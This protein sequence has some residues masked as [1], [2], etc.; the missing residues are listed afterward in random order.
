MKLALGTAQF[1]L[2][3]GIANQGGR[4]SLT[5]AKKMMQFAVSQGIYTIDTAIDYGDSEVCL[6]EI[7]VQ[8]LKVITKLP[9]MPLVCNDTSRW[10]IENITRSMLRLGCRELY[11]LMLHRSTDLQGESGLRLYKAIQSLK[12]EGL[13]KKIGVSIYSPT[14]L[15][16]I[17][18][19]FCLDIIQAPF[20]LVDQRLLITGWLNR[21]K[22]SGI[23]IHTRSCFLQGLLLMPKKAIPKKFLKWNSLWNHWDSWLT[24]NHFPASKVCLDFV[25]SFNQIDQIVVGADNLTQL[26]QI[27]KVATEPPCRIFPLLES[28]DE[29]LINPSNWKYLE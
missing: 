16:A 14:E 26:E 3:Y 2:K 12:T 4:V 7:G 25:Q 5:E 18:P 20:N 8:N 27:V 15:D 17:F 11:G 28:N 6:G 19:K 13:V 9:P 10:V 1:G 23:E 21:L 29:Y 22:N 24:E